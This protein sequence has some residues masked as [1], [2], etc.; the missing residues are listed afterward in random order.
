M[1]QPTSVAASLAPVQRKN[2][3]IK[4]LAK[5]EP[6]T[7]LA[8][9]EKVSRKFLY[10]QCSKANSALDEAFTPCNSNQE[11]LFYLPVTQTWLFQL[12]L[13]LILICHCSYRGVKELL[14]DLF[15]TQ[16]SLG[17]I[18][19]LLHS[20][21]VKAQQINQKQDLSSVQVGLHDEI[22]QGSQPVLAG[23]DAHLFL[24]LSLDHCCAPR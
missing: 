3:A 23:V 22:F 13:A 14:R 9:R 11:V 16:L 8:A 10:Q 6:L 20:T 21:A 15:D 12:I 18:H 7:H 5:N 17:S 2:L 1:S 4:V 19:N 24:L